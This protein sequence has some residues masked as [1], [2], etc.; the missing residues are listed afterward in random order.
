MAY[1]GLGRGC[2]NV[3]YSFLCRRFP[4]HVF[5]SVTVQLNSRLIIPTACN[6]TNLYFEDVFNP[7]ELTAAS[8]KGPDTKYVLQSFT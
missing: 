2:I 1:M 7:A 4:L 6:C 3:S 8:K 5:I